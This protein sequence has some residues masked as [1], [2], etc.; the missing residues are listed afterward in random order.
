MQHHQTEPEIP[1]FDMIAARATNRKIWRATALIVAG[2]LAYASFLPPE[3]ALLTVGNL[4][5]VFAMAA[6]VLAVLRLQPLWAAHLT[7]W[8]MSLMLLA[9]SA[10]AMAAFELPALQ[11]YFEAGAATEAPAAIDEAA[12]T[13]QAAAAETEL[14]QAVPDVAPLG[15]DEEVQ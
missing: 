9:V 10:A 1:D 12:A 13:A 6:A 14:E 15:I 3:H 2:T 4:L 5:L 8:D 7:F 11:T